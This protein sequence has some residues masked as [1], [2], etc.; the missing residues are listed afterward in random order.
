VT[1]ILA[2]NDVA[3]YFRILQHHFESDAWREIWHGLQ[4]PVHTFRDV[5][6]PVDASDRIVWRECQRRQVILVTANRNDDGPDSLV[7]VIRQLNTVDCLPVIT[8]ADPKRI[9]LE[10]SYASRVAERI[11]E[12]LMDVEQL[13]GAGRLFVP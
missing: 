10:K 9:G 3:G 11:L 12:F 8:L 1:G 7:A 2:D 5:G 4:C 13:R 6:L